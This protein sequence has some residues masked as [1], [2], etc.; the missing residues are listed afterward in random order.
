MKSGVAN[1]SA[2]QVAK[3]LGAKQQVQSTMHAQ[4]LAHSFF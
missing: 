3:Q 1:M 2:C 4:S